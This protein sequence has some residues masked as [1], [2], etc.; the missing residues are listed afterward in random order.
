MTVLSE[1]KNRQL[2]ISTPLQVFP[3]GIAVGSMATVSSL[4]I[5]HWFGEITYQQANRF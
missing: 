2:L 5:V 1:V 3:C 4:A